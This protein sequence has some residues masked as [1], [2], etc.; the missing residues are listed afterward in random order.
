MRLG[1]AHGARPFATGHFVQIGFLLFV[2]AM[3]RQSCIGT[4]R[5]A[6]V[7]GPS[8]VGR[9]HHLVKTLVHHQ[10]QTLTAIRWVARKC[11]P[12]A[13]DVL[14]VSLFETFGRCHGVRHF[15]MLAAF[16]IATDVQRK[17]HLRR[18]LAAFF[19]N[20]INGLNIGVGKLWNRLQISGHIQQLVHH[21]LHIT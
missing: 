17:N 10:W 2:C 11:W 18:K 6:W 15:V 14:V 19:Q 3:R 7:H 4:V 12:A 8:L 5:Q 20:R 16:L 13:S 1:Q 21:K 9:V